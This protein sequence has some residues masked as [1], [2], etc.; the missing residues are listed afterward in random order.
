MRTSRA[1]FEPH[2]LASFDVNVNGISGAAHPVAASC[3]S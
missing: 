3:T 1:G 2:L